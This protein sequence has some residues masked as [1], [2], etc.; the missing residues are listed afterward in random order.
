MA[1]RG[2]S[3]LYAG[4]LRLTV[5]G[6]VLMCVVVLGE[7]AVVRAQTAA[8]PTDQASATLCVFNASSATL[9]SG[10]INFKVDGTKFTSL[11]RNQYSCKPV[12]PGRHVVTMDSG[13]QLVI[14]EADAS[15]TYYVE[16]AYHPSIIAMFSTQVFIEITKDEAD[17]FMSQMTSVD[18]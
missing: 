17:K 13:R 3:H 8:Q 10:N 18:K 1:A 12:D 5:C 4:G 11:G 9:F 15:E 6:F 7:N 2:G 16:Y 14:D